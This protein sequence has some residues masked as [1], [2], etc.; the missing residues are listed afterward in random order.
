[1]MAIFFL[2]ISLTALHEKVVLAVL[3]GFLDHLVA[4]SVCPCGDV[5]AR[6]RIGGDD[7]E[8]FTGLHRV[9][10]HFRLDNGQRATHSTAVNFIVMAHLSSS[11]NMDWVSS[12]QANILATSGL[13]TL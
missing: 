2:A 13:A 6:T 5:F 8:N 4:H 1:M 7:F 3:F 9:N 12:R 10:L 11:F